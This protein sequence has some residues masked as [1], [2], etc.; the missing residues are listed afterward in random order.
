MTTAMARDDGAS[1]L[2]RQRDEEA[3][4]SIHPFR[5]MINDIR[6]R[7]PYY[8]SDWLDAWD[9][10]VVPA[11]VFMFFAN[12]LPA[13]AFSLDMFQ[14]TGSNYGVNEVLLA[15]VLGAV[16]FSIF[17]AQPLVI[18]GV[19]GPITVFNSTVYN[20]MKPTGV[21]YLGFMTWIGM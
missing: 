14:N 9:Y 19:T 12:I 3:W 20:I 13:L 6:R 15:S 11:T 10:R 18:V 8:V 1:T 21:N 17:S 5:G 7:A 16:V 2:T 4:W